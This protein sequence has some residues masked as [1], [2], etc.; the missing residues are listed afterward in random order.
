MDRSTSESPHTLGEAR[1]FNFQNA[2]RLAPWF[3]KGCAVAAL[4][5]WG[6]A[7]W[8]S[9]QPLP[10][11]PAVFAGAWCALA[12]L[13]FVGVIR[14]GNA[15]DD[16]RHTWGAQ[17]LAFVTLG[18]GLALSVGLGVLDTTQAPDLVPFALWCTLSAGA[19]LMRPR[20][21]AVWYATCGLA[22]CVGVAWAP[23]QQATLG[24]WWFFGAAACAGGWGLSGLLWHRFSTES[25]LR[26]SL[27]TSQSELQL[28]QR[29]LDR[30]VR[31]D[32]LTG[33][34]NRNT[35]LE[36][37]RNELRRAQRQGS[38]TTVLLIDL[39]YFKRVND[40]WGH[41]AGDA[42]LRHVAHTMVSNLRSTDLVGRLGGEEFIVLLPH[43][44]A[45]MGRNIAEKLRHKLQ[46]SEVFW[47]N[48]RIAVTASIGMS[49][50]KPT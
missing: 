7:A 8:Q 6:L 9:A 27:E 35:F 38:N 22:L 29:E 1:A 50:A 28:K 12:A 2:R 13:A 15:L 47:E 30:L 24:T 49:C 45:E 40:T 23:T 21:A 43:T 34:F 16:R 18:L 48:Q 42:V 5:F 4:W 44:S 32:G 46:H 10:A 31:Q 39:D 14:W 19:V 11:G 37:G 36:L 20:A 3:A 26:R 33:L 25:A 41:P 17:A